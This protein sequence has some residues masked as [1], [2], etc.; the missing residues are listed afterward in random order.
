MRSRVEQAVEAFKANPPPL[1]VDEIAEAIKLLQWLCVD[2]FTFLGL[3]YT[4]FSP[5]VARAEPA[6]SRMRG[7]RRTDD[8]LGHQVMRLLGLGFGA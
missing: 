2:N 1:P 3:R 8:H 7:D 4:R 6:I 5:S